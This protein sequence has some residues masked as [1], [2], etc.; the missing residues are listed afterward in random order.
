MEETFE[1]RELGDDLSLERLDVIDI[2]CLNLIQIN[3][4]NNINS[5][6]IIYT[7]AP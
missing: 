5:L 3:D 7:Y 2:D 1:L 6:E 4:D